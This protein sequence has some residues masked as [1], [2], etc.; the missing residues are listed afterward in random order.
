MYVVKCIQECKI[1]KPIYTIICDQ[2]I[3]CSE[4]EG[5]LPNK[6]PTLLDLVSGLLGLPK[7]LDFDKSLLSKQGFLVYKGILNGENV[8]SKLHSYG[9]KDAKK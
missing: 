6:S 7:S 3:C 1:Q 4:V 2:G 9:W 5:L 8:I